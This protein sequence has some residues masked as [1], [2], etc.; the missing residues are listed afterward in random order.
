MPKTSK[1]INKVNSGWLGLRE[2]RGCREWEVTT[3]G[4][5]V[6]SRRDENVLKLGG[7]DSCITLWIYSNT[8]HWTLLSL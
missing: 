5:S 8:L 6:G 7:G 4:Y 3:N 1:S 2:A